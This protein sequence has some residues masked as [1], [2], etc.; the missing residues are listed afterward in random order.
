[1]RPGLPSSSVFNI[2][3]QKYEL[4]I[5]C[6]DFKFK[7]RGTRWVE[8]P[9]IFNIFYL[10]H[11]PVLPKRRALKKS[12]L[13]KKIPISLR[14]T[15]GGAELGAF[16]KAVVECCRPQTGGSPIIVVVLLATYALAMFIGRCLFL[17]SDMDSVEL[18]I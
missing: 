12:V 7:Q 16:L 18:G 9:R 15:P 14:H 3:L 8:S 17:I 5:R 4:F 6:S 11:G 10:K 1:M 13:S 2:C